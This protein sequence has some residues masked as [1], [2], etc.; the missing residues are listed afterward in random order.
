M[1]WGTVELATSIQLN[2]Y[3]SIHPFSINTC[4]ERTN[5]TLTHTGKLPREG[6][7]V[8]IKPTYLLIW[9]ASNKYSKIQFL[10]NII[11]HFYVNNFNNSTQE[12][13]HCITNPLINVIH[14][15]VKTNCT[16]T[17]MINLSKP[18][19]F[20]NETIIKL[21]LP[22]TALVFVLEKWFVQIILWLCDL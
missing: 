11:L 22:Q 16:G 18:F 21:V 20:T 5:H 15:S 8:G 7:Q 13:F 19:P 14:Y 6:R 10:L 17:S 12:C 9:L 3:N 1:F 2:W 4:P